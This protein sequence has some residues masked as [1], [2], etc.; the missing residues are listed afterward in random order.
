MALDVQWLHTGDSASHCL[1]A[2]L[3]NGYLWVGDAASACMAALET[4]LSALSCVAAW[5]GDAGA[6]AAAAGQ[7]SRVLLYGIGCKDVTCSSQSEHVSALASAAAKK[8]KKKVRHSLSR[9]P[10]PCA[11]LSAHAS[12]RAAHE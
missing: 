4:P 2:A 3:R 9:L 5:H 8:K 1:I 12:L 6:Y 11:S 10:Q 7:G